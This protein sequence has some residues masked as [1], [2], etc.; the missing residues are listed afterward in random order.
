MYI[1]STD[2]YILY[3]FFLSVLLRMAL[4]NNKLGECFYLDSDEI[5]EVSRQI[6]S[7]NESG[8][9]EYAPC[10]N[11]KRVRFLSKVN[12]KI[13]NEIIIPPVF[14]NGIFYWCFLGIHLSISKDDV[15]K[16]NLKLHT[17]ELKLERKTLFIENIQIASI[18]GK[19]LMCLV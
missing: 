16:N 13:K 5:Y 14:I 1:T 18:H 17:S 15:M 4:T 12:K 6:L 19:D 7:F 2:I 3:I 8:H 9:D 11:I 10:L